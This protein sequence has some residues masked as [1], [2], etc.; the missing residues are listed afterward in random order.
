M[1]T[2]ISKVS[3]LYHFRIILFL[4]I[5]YGSPKTTNLPRPSPLSDVGVNDL[6]V[7]LSTVS[8]SHISNFMQNI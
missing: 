7:A 4:A 6:K 2:L 3:V 8:K 1:N 5:C